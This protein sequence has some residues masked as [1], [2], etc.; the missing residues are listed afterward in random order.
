MIQQQ[1]KHVAATLK[2]LGITQNYHTLSNRIIGSILIQ[3]SLAQVCVTVCAK[4][5][6]KHTMYGS[7][8]FV[9]HDYSL[10]ANIN[11]LAAFRGF[12]FSSVVL[13][14]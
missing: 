14:Q 8:I 5:S 6:P 11:A 10:K 9:L 2:N 4:A 12:C 13:H 1:L 3:M 7:I